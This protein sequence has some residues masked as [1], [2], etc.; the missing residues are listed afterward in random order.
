VKYRDFLTLARLRS[1]LD[2]LRLVG[3]V[4]R[5]RDGTWQLGLVVRVV[6][7]AQWEAEVALVESRC[8]AVDVRPNG[9]DEAP[10]A[11]REEKRWIS[12]MQ[13]LRRSH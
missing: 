6:D 13:Q 8:S 1:G 4:R 9:R 3:D 5:A 10:R 2:G 11:K 12:S 7:P